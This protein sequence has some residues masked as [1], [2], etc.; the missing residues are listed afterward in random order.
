MPKIPEYTNNIFPDAGPLA[1]QARDA[2]QSGYY[3]GQMIEGAFRD[4]GRGLGAFASRFE[5]DDRQASQEEIASLTAAV[6]ETNANLSVQ[7]KQKLSQSDPGDSSTATKFIEEDFK[8]AF[9]TIG[10][11]LKTEKARQ[12]FQT[13]RARA[14]KHFY[15]S[16]SADQANVAAQW[17]AEQVGKVYS[18][19]SVSIQSSP[20]SWRSIIE[21]SNEAIDALSEAHG[22]DKGTASK[23]KDEN[24]RKYAQTAAEQWIHDS[25]EQAREVIKR[26][27]FDDFIDGDQKQKLL[28]DADRRDAEL[29]QNE[30]AASAA[31]LKQ[32]QREA[33]AAINEL[34]L[35]VKPGKDGRF[36]VPPDYMEKFDALALQYKDV[37]SPEEIQARRNWAASQARRS[38]TGDFPARNDKQ[39]VL[40][41]TARALKKTLTE[42]EILQAATDGRLTESGFNHYMGLVNKPVNAS[43]EASQ[44]RKWL[45]SK[46][47][48]ITS[49][50]VGNEDTFGADRYQDYEDDMMEKYDEF[51][52]AG[53]SPKEWK[54]Y[55]NEALGSYEYSRTEAMEFFKDT[56]K[57]SEQITDVEAPDT[58]F[59]K[60]EGESASNYINRIMSE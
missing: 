47:S 34:Q 6:A 19:F 36:E 60:R 46:K 44:A 2:A 17:G 3:R 57:K 50:A 30:L 12:Y 33:S 27:D 29:D 31:A 8:K 9:D 23:L 58:W 38:V 42:A 13:A 39:T 37:L 43:R 25:P 4:L 24:N 28:E 59:N 26:G 20:T 18:Q 56:D 55:A 45:R 49:S 16:V 48:F 15:T 40:D 1:A 52:A 22:I 21:Q 32:R 53:K 14:F 41:F 35:S 5:Q 51:I 11:D 10:A 7:W 54:E